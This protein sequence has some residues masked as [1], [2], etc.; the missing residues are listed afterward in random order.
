MMTKKSFV[1][2]TSFAYLKKRFC[3]RRR[4]YEISWSVCDCKVSRPCLIFSRN[5]QSSLQ[6]H[7][8]YGRL[9]A[10][11][12][13]NTLKNLLGTNTSAYPSRVCQRQKGFIELILRFFFRKFEAY[14][15]LHNNG[16]SLS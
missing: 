4:C 6:S 9:L 15:R 14:I 3:Q 8:G 5:E 10:L 12:A 2:P 13:N 16:A 1:R 7:K 11:A